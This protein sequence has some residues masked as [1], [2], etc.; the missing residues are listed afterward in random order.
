VVGSS[1][2][3]HFQLRADETP[4]LMKEPKVEFVDDGPGKPVGINRFIGRRPILAFGNSDGDQQ[5]LEWTAAGRGARFMGLVHHTDAAREWA[6]DRQSHIGKLDKA[7]DEAT[8]R[9]WTV[10]DMKSDWKVVYAFQK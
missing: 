10:V 3:T 1:G 6:Y 4:V 7:L 8:K 5:M 2:V 9:Q